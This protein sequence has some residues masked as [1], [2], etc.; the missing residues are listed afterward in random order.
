MNQLASRLSCY[1]ISLLFLLFVV[2]FSLKVYLL[3][4]SFFSYEERHQS[5][6][7]VVTRHKDSTTYEDFISRVYSP[8]DMSSPFFVSNAVASSTADDTGC[9]SNPSML[10]AALLDSHGLAHKFY[11]KGDQ[12]M[13]GK[14]FH[15]V[16]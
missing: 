8:V 1:L 6:T 14:Y 4:V 15:V 9:L 11:Q 16:N 7:T 3:L 10:A 2:L 5:L 13:R 12:K